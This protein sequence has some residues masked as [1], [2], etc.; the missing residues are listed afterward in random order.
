MACDMHT[1]KV[2]LELCILEAIAVNKSGDPFAMARTVTPA[3]L[4]FIRSESAITFRMGQKLDIPYYFVAYEILKR[5]SLF[6][7]GHLHHPE[8]IYGHK[9]HSHHTPEGI[10]TVSNVHFAEM[11]AQIVDK[12]HISYT[13][14]RV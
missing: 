12:V 9:K 1:R 11:P 7:N 8:H 10:K 4:S 5:Y 13:I 3:V 14:W 2:Y 6:V